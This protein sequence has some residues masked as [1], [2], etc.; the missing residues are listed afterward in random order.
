MSNDRH[1]VRREVLGASQPALSAGKVGHCIYVE[2]SEPRGPELLECGYSR[3]ALERQIGAGPWC[4][5]GHPSQ[6]PVIDAGRSDYTLKDGA[7]TGDAEYRVVYVNPETGERSD[8]S[9]PIPGAGLA[10][11]DVLTVQQVKDRY[12][13]GIDLTNDAGEPLPDATFAHY[14]LSAIDV[15]E[16]ELDTPIIP[17]TFCENHDFH[18]GLWQNYTFLPLDNSPLIEV[19]E[20]RVTYPSNDVVLVYPGEWLK[21]DRVAAQVQVLPTAGTLDQI[22]LGSGGTY[23]PTLYAGRDYLPSLFQVL[24]T[25]GFERGRVPRSLVNAIGMLA[26]MGPFHIFG[27]LIAGAGIA[28]VSLSMD[29][30]SQSIGTTS[31]AT[32]SG[33]GSR[34]LNYQKELKT[35]IP[36]LRKTYKR[37][38][39]QVA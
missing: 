14:V 22:L 2:I 17:T 33:Y 7:G 11:Q 39:M 25:A 12:F 1:M 29:G 37:V 23:L 4:E 38:G 19:E 5:V 31:S 34:V 15:L 36:L 10:I 35:L 6:R 32:N 21:I 28:N 18:R 9:D 8:P 20:F 3:I 13:F 27:D 16:H 24:Y 26:A 30:L